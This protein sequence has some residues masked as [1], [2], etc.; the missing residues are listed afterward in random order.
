MSELTV[1]RRLTTAFIAT[2]PVEIVLRPRVKQRTNNGGYRW[3]KG[4]PHPVQTMRLVEPSTVNAAMPEP[5]ATADGKMREIVFMLLGEWDAVIGQHDTFTLD[6]YD[7]EVWQL[8]P[9]NGWE[10]RASAVRLG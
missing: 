8:A 10:R 1:Q 4:V 2:M 6:G 9:F 3:S 7:Y 5:Q